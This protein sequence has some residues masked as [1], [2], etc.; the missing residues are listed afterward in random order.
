MPCGHGNACGIVYILREHHQVSA[1]V[2]GSGPPA[3]PMRF[4]STMPATKPFDL[5]TATTPLTPATA[6]IALLIDL[7][8][9]YLLQ[10]RDSIPEIFYP[11]HWGFFGGTIEPGETEVQAVRREIR[12]ETGLSIA[13]D[14]LRYFS[15]F[16]FD[17]ARAGG[18]VIARSFYEAVVTEEEIAAIRLGEGSGFGL[19]T[20]SEALHAYK[21]TPYDAFALWMHAAQAR[22]VFPPERRTAQ[23]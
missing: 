1:F 18:D 15:R 20:A 9:R 22:F 12:E 14:R 4:I 5:L 10:Q 19:L 7:E 21:L 6:A 11:G 16:S 13:A 3:Q 17:F 8:G 2:G 23:S